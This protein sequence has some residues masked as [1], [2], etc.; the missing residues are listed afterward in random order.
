MVLPYCSRY[1]LSA[2]SL[3]VFSGQK[4]QLVIFQG[5]VVLC[6]LVTLSVQPFLK[7][8]KHI[9]AS[10]QVCGIGILIKVL[11]DGDIVL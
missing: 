7:V 1:W 3:C 11:I 9:P 2:F 8:N 5:V 10:P 4:R 6:S